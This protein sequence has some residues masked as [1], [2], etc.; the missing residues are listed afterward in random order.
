MNV[1]PG[2]ALIGDDKV[3]VELGWGDDDETTI[4]IHHKLEK[5]YTNG[6]G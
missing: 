5:F 4:R 6:Q 3:R 2:K 1:A